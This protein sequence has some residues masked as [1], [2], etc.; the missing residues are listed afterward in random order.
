LFVTFALACGHGG[1]EAATAPAAPMATAVKVV[2][3]GTEPME[4]ATTTFGTIE[5]LQT[6]ELRPEASGTVARVAF[7]D[8]DT[9]EKGQL[10]L[11][12]RDDAAKAQ[13]AD[14]EARLALADAKHGRVAALFE[15]QNTSRQE[16]DQATA[17]R[18][19]ARAAVDLARDAVRKTEVRA[20]FDGVVGRREVSVGASVGPSTTVTRIEDLTQVTVDLAL[21]ERLLSVVAVGSAVRVRV[22]AFPADVF[23]GEIKYVA[24]R[25]DEATRTVEV[26]AHVPNEDRRLR[27]GLSAEVE[28]VTASRPDALMVPTQAVQTTDKGTT[29]FVVDA[30]SKAQIRPVKTGTR[31]DDRVEVLE[32]LAA[33]DKVVVEGLVRLAPG[34]AVRITE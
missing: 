34:A 25:I 20:P 19:L 29:V 7:E 4:R 14:A 3:V 27:P 10:L 21:P 6:A 31:T 23:E 8:G 9:V 12:L 33:G 13:Q 11:K 16:L 2:T 28:V 15:K 17:E 22:D 24:P 26:R 32:G 1:E 30:E 18:D 5:A